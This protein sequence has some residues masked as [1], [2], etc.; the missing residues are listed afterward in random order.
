MLCLAKEGV[1][2]LS[3]HVRYARGGFVVEW[4]MLLVDT[5]CERILSNYLQSV[6]R[7]AE[8]Y[9]WGL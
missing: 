1:L 3:G 8:I 4:L 7:R 5:Q 2:N 9:L 6:H